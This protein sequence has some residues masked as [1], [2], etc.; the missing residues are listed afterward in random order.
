MDAPVR[1][2]DLADATARAELTDR[3]GQRY[4]GRPVI[5][6]PMVLAGATR[7][8][9]LFRR[10]RCPVLVVATS[11]GAGPVPAPEEATV[12]M[13]DQPPTSTMTDEVRALD[14][15]V[16]DLPPHA[17][18]AIEAFDPGREGVWFTPAFVRT[19]EPLLGRPVTGGRPAAFATLEDK[20]LAD[21]VWDAAGVTRA[22]SRIVPV[23]RDALAAATA[24]LAGPL[25]AV[26]S[27][28][29]RDGVSGGGNF[30]R[31]VV[32]EPDRHAAL[33]FFASR[34]DR[35]RVMPFLDGVPC[36]VPG[37][38]LPAPA[39]GRAT[40]A[41][42]PLELVMMRDVA[43][44]RFVYGGMG[45]HWDP[46]PAVRD[47]M[48]EAVRRVGDHLAAAHGYR[49]F[50]GVDGVLTADGFRPTELNPRMTAGVAMVARVAPD[51]FTLLQTVLVEGGD[52]ELVPA[53][54]EALVPL[55]DAERVGRVVARGEG[56]DHIVGGDVE[57]P[58]VY[59]D[60]R[61]DR[62]PDGGATGN[63][64]VAADLPHGFFAAV[65]PCAALV[66]GRRVAEVNVALVDFVDRE[67]GTGLGPVEMAPD[68]HRHRE[69]DQTL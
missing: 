49:G 12:V 4:A 17:V 61:F 3:L 14:P 64:F 29:A 43:R 42:R 21:A 23:D 10:L 25:G 62:A 8:V 37:V 53:D 33:D 50:F 6:G 48:R 56:E 67:L 54:L 36:S 28:D 47:E 68:L 27:G 32:D 59:A 55:M 66:P 40:A 1:R 44:R 45:S 11:R 34:C 7:H 2:R 13:V 26:W 52:P 9:G 46:P 35:V 31:W 24:E 5:V 18:A 22:P 20:T 69:V 19:D 38:V 16:R 58:L 39:G 57:W 15:L 60:G 41:F 63:V 65:D 51:L 30:V